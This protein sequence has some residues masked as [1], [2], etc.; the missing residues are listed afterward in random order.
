MVNYKKIYI[1]LGKRY[2]IYMIENNHIND[3]L[4]FS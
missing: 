3:M 4:E 1:N 2:N